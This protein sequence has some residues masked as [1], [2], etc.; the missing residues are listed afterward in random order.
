MPLTGY[1]GD[2]LVNGTDLLEAPG[3][4]AVHLGYLGGVSPEDFKGA[5]EVSAEELAELDQRLRDTERWPVFRID[6]PSGAVFRV[7]YRN[8]NPD[9]GIDFV[10][11]HPRWPKSI[12]LAWHDERPAWP[13]LCW[14][15]LVWIA[16]HP[17]STSRWIVGWERRL[18]LFLPAMGDADLPSSAVDTVADA[19]NRVGAGWASHDLATGLTSWARGP[20]WSYTPAGALVCDAQYAVRSSLR[21]GLSR[22]FTPAQALEVTR[23]FADPPRRRRVRNVNSRGLT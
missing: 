4:W 9:N 20:T 3:F 12:L 18:L 22:S 10:F 11:S 19:L 15:E 17:P 5:F 8:R 16:D 23:A 7:I 6:L 21:L 14:R 1:E 13:G 2:P